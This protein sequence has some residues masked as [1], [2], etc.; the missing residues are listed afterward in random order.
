MFLVPV[1]FDGTVHMFMFLLLKAVYWILKWQTAPCQLGHPSHH[2]QGTNQGW[3]MK[4]SEPSRGSGQLSASYRTC[5]VSRPLWLKGSPKDAA[6]QRG[7]ERP[8][9]QTYAAAQLSNISD[10]LVVKKVKN[11]CIYC[12]T[13]LWIIRN[14]TVSV[15]FALLATHHQNKSKAALCGMSPLFLHVFL[16]MQLCVRR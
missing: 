14:D 13:A 12:T 7:Q 1:P 3:T 4:M 2:Q 8:L 6:G 15:I 10:L 5:F 11:H 16:K 9:P